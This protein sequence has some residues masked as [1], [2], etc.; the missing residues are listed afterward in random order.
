MSEQ[1][2][3]AALEALRDPKANSHNPLYVPPS[4]STVWPV[5]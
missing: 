2:F 1:A 4:T 3:I 5:M